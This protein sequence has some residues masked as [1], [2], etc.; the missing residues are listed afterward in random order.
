MALPA[1]VRVKLSSEAAGAIDITPVVVQELPIRDL[2]GHMLAIAG[3]DEARLREILLRGSLTIGAS[4]L[5]WAGWEADRDSLRELLEAFPDPD[6]TLVFEPGRCTRAVLSGG[7]QPIEIG[8]EAASSRGLFQRSGFWEELMEL[9]SGSGPV[10]AG[11]SYRDAADR[12][13]CLLT[14]GT[15]ARLRAAAQSL[16]H[17]SLRARIQTEAFAAV[18]VYTER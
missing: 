16:R 10:Y 15:C 12:Y 14:A 9:V 2:V 3:K 11:Y 1:T 6:P 4:R 17:S 7:R 18:E 13:R 5:R 8:R